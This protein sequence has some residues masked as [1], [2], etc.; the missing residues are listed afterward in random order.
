MNYV[1]AFHLCIILS[2]LWIQEFPLPRKLIAVDMHNTIK[3]VQ[4]AHQSRKRMK[5]VFI[6]NEEVFE[7]LTFSKI[8]KVGLHN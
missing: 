3:I 6:S 1:T 2:L 4:T 7:L 8:F 5:F